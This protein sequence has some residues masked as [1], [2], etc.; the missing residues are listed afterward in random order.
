MANSIV[1]F[2]IDNP[3]A[4][5]LVSVGSFVAAQ[6]ACAATSPVCVPLAALAVFVIAAESLDGLAT[7]AVAALRTCSRGEVVHCGLWV[8][9]GALAIAGG[10]TA[11]RVGTALAGTYFAKRAYSLAVESGIGI[12][13]ASANLGTSKSLLLETLRFRTVVDREVPVCELTCA[14]IDLVTRSA[15]GTL[16][17]IEVKNGTFARF[18]S[19]QNLVYPI[20]KSSGASFPRGLAGLPPHIRTLAVEVQ[21]WGASTRLALP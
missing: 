11:V 12:S 6:V 5:L 13:Q 3:I 21:H 15:S 14:R 10:V 1:K 9:G 7:S 20:L 8:A 17:A 18:T 2:V 4:R 19:N 16:R